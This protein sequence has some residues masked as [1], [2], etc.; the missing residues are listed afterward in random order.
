MG[1]ETETPTPE[2]VVHE[3]PL[4]PEEVGRYSVERDPAAEQDIADYVH[5]QA[6]EEFVRH[7]ERVKIEY[8]MG[9]S[10]EIWDVTTDKN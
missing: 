6:R 8:V 4:P 10:Y 9:D 2:C 1:S 7:I 3:H 5:G